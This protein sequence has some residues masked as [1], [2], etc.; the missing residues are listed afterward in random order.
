VRLEQQAE[1]IEL[2]IKEA[3]LVAE[4]TPQDEH[5]DKLYRLQIPK[6]K[7]IRMKLKNALLKI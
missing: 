4:K 2:L 6:Q 3:H 1:R 7:K 5:V